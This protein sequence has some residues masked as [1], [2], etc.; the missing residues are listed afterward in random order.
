M[1]ATPVTVTVMPPLS[2]TLSAPDSLCEGE[3]AIISIQTNG[4]DGNYGYAWSNGLTGAS[5]SVIILT[6]TTINIIISDGC[7]TPVIQTSVSIIAVSAPAVTF[8]LP[9]QGGC[10]PYDAVFTIPQ[11][12]PPYQY[13]WNFGDG[14]TS[15]QD[16]VHH[17]YLQDGVYDVTLT[18]SQMVAGGC[19]TVLNFQN[20]V[21]V[22]PMPESRFIYDPPVP[23]RNH[24]DVYFTDRSTGAIFWYWNFGDSTPE[25]R[26]Q[27]P[28]HVYRDTGVYMVSLR[29]VSNDGCMDST[30]QEVEIKDDFEVF[31]PNAFTPDGSGTNDYFKIYGV[32]ITSY[33]LAIFD[34]W[35]KMVHYAK[36]KEEAWDG[37]DDATGILVPQ[38]LYVYKIT[39]IDNMGNVHDRFNHVT[40]IR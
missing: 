40:V 28:H 34:R 33:E 35:G 20:A 10:E 29:I 13:V 16:S 22:K 7:S 26:E 24:P 32:G 4:G 37:T 2:F 36:N 38:G 19:E 12:L 21:D 30:L 9:Q 14:Y 6:D 18:I 15:S 39:I 23:T 17:T 1:N 8:N 3:A 25:G 27:N 31:I 11:G 5:N